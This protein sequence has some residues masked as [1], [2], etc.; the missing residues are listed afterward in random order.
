[1]T[2]LQGLVSA[3]GALAAKLVESRKSLLTARAKV[4]S[5]KEQEARVD[6]EKA[7]S[8]KPVV[9]VYE[10]SEQCMVCLNVT[11]IGC[12]RAEK[13]IRA[14]VKESVCAVDTVVQQMG[15]DAVSRLR[16]VLQRAY[17]TVSVPLPVALTRV[18]GV[19]STSMRRKGERSGDEKE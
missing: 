13:L 16:H 11:M 17:L 2:E 6:T 7:A 9:D 1:M 15:Y 8:S 10:E 19:A 4:G 12:N 3:P 14:L 18:S 5:L